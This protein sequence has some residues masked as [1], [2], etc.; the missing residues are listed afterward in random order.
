[1]VLLQAFTDVFE[2]DSYVAGL[3]V[4]AVDDEAPARAELAYVLK[5]DD[6]IGEVRTAQNGTEAL[7][8]LQTEPIDAVFL[9][10]RMPGIDG[11]DLAKVLK[12]FTEAPAIVF[13]T[14]FEDH[15]VSAFDL[16]AVDYVLKPYRPER[17]HE[18]VSRVLESKAQ[19][20]PSPDAAL[21]GSEDETI[22]VELAGVTRFI[23]RSDIRYVE[24][25]GDYARLVTRDG[26]HL[27]RIPLAV[28]EERWAD[29]GFVRIHRRWLVSL[30]TIDEVRVDAGR[31]SVRVGD[32][33]LEVSRRH[34]RELRDRLVRSARPRRID[35]VAAA[36]PVA[37]R[38]KP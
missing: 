33:L 36:P 14:A 1:M 23:K 18:A 34:T 2:R 29:A 20:Q 6:R 7:K 37:N 10:I 8:V 11:M 12:R 22:P 19:R 31:M 26:R 27:V 35:G 21:S 4:L 28:L 17:L 30:A 3:R 15:A 13:V 24:A 25:H 9:D 5:Q 16:R 32:A 38:P